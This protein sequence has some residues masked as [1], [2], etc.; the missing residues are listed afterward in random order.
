MRKNEYII[1]LYIY[2]AAAFLTGLCNTLFNLEMKSK[3]ENV[4]HAWKLRV[5]NIGISIVVGIFMPILMPFLIIG[6][7]VILL[8]RL[9]HCMCCPFESMTRISPIEQV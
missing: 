8:Y 1:L 4:L 5:R 7:I 9:F 3:P 2:I 6:L